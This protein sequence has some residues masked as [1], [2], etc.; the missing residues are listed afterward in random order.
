MP[1]LAHAA[2]NA[3]MGFASASRQNGM[4]GPRQLLEA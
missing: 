3:A 2:S 1:T 4:Q